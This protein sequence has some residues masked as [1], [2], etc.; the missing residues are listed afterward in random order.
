MFVNRI[1]LAAAFT[2]SAALLASAAPVT[3]G[4]VCTGVPKMTRIGGYETGL[5]GVGASEIVAYDPKRQQMLITNAENKTVDIIDISVPTK[6]VKVG[7]FTANF[8]NSSAIN[9]VDVFGDIAAV[10]VQGVVKTDPGYIELWNLEG[11]EPKFLKAVEVCAQP[12]SV[13]F[14]PNGHWVLAPCEGEPNDDYSV[15]PEGGIAIIDLSSGPMSATS[16]VADFKKFNGANKPAGLRVS[17][18]A[19]TVAHDIEPEYI[20]V[21]SDSKTAYVS[22]QENN[23]LAVVN[24]AEASVEK[25]YALGLKNH[26]I[27]GNGLD[28]SDRDGKVDIRTWNNVVGM[29]MPDTINYYEEKG[30]CNKTKGEYIFTANEGDGRGYKA[31]TDESRVSALKLNNTFFNANDTK[32]LARLTVSNDDGFDLINGT[33]IFHT[34]HAYG[35]RSFSI[36]N[37]RTGEQVFDSADQIEQ[38]TAEAN[39][40]HFNSAHDEAKSFDTRSD[41]KGPEV[42]VLKIGKI[43]KI[44]LVF[45]GL[46]RQSGV[47]MYD[48]SNV[49]APKLLQYLNLRDFEADIKLQGDL[50]P[51]GMDFVYESDSPTGNPLLLVG[52]EVSGSTAIY[53]I[54]C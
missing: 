36:W 30:E 27:P 18:K 16:K 38:V 28:A 25:I 43:G 23:G 32:A 44:P 53:E 19:A 42:E 26:S 49:K 20:A 45:V 13:V 39:P 50:G 24:I 47:L 22:L 29:Y 54:T 8:A 33:K 46:E 48:I 40:K 4:M 31:F 52:N 7:A 15:D 11:K 14:S 6:V 10:A 3:S 35:S 41:N 1:V 12:D 5:F 9:S 2:A 34:L 37:A 21:S 17:S 51:E